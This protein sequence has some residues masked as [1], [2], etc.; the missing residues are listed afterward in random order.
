ME[1]GLVVTPFLPGDSLLFA[2]GSISSTG[3]FNLLLVMI[4]CI[5]AAFVGDTV[6]YWIGRS[7]GPKIFE[8]NNPFFKKAYLEK[9][10]SFYKK[11]GGFAIILSRFVPIVRTF[12]PCVAG[13]SKMSYP[14]FLLYNIIGG[15]LWVLLFTSLGFFFGNI[16]LV[17]SHFELVMV[18][19]VLVSVV[20]LV[21]EFIKGRRESST[22]A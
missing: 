3:E 16:P 12:A 2:A 6:N 5:I 8:S 1:T 21:I 10:Q 17:K 4:V 19:I 22:Q 15:T 13:I 9:A 11:H 7:V 18:A 14:T 20:P